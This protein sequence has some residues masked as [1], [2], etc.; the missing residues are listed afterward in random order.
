MSVVTDRNIIG[1]TLPD[2]ALATD[3]H[4]AARANPY[5]PRSA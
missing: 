4:F 5:L 1:E 3:R 2:L